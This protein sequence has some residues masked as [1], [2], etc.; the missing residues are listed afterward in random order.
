ME[1]KNEGGE[2]PAI[3]CNYGVRFYIDNTR[4]PQ[5]TFM[6]YFHFH[7]YEYELFYMKD[8]QNVI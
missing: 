4:H 7:A 1:I 2:K 3:E 6:P 8:A 5:G